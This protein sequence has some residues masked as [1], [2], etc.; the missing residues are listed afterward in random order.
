MPEYL[1]PGVYVEEI[2]IGVEPIQGV[3]TS[4]AAMVGVTERGPDEPT[5][6]TSFTEFIDKFGNPIAPSPALYDE[7]ALHK[8]ERG[9]WWQLPLAVKGFFENGGRFLIIK[10]ISISNLDELTADD[11][12]TAIQSLKENQD[13]ALYL[14]PGM[15]S[16]K[17]QKA[18]IERCE[19]SGDCFAVLDPPNGLDIDGI[20][21][22]RQ[23]FNSSFAA[24]YYPWL[25]VADLNGQ[26]V[27][28]A[29]SGHVAGIYARVDADRGVHKPPVNETIKG[30][31]KLERDVTEN[32]QA[33]LNP[34]GI[35]ALRFFSGRGN[36]VW[37]ART[38]S[39]DPEWKY[40]NVRRLL[41]F[42]EQSIQQGM[43]FVE[44]EPNTVQTWAN[45]RQSVSDFLMNSWRNGAL[46]GTKPEQAF[47]VKCDRTTMT[48]NDLDNGRLICLVGVAPLKPAEFV[49]FR[50]GQ[51]TLDRHH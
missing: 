34:E 10:R 29:P 14:A 21:Q 3:K 8:A 41:M 23:R 4:T 20:R 27:E 13:A 5:L 24:L 17:V 37:G 6:I 18:L 16:T 47:F 33:K 40:V 31:T 32:E 43:Q 38:I 44:F 28:L 49:I 35:N 12:V 30:I 46:Q 26:K 9:Q 45:V 25:E 19:S 22:F 51:W 42:I 48:Q 50:I 1:P 11:F 39:N 7:W 2:P 15:W 36:V